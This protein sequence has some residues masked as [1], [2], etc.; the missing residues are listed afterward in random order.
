MTDRAILF[1]TAFL[2]ALATGL[3]GVLLGIY[4]DKLAFPPAQIGL[5]IGAG[6]TGAA[7]STFLVT[8][9][10]DRLG[11][12]RS[13]LALSLASAA[14]GFALLFTTSW[15][16]VCAVAFFGM[17]NGMG[18]D[19]G[20]ALVLEQAILPGTV[21]DAGRT[22]VFAW[23]NVLQD[24][25]HAI[26]G[27]LAVLPGAARLLTGAEEIASFQLA[28]ALYAF[29]LLASGL[30][31]LRLTPAIGAGRWASARPAS[32]RIGA[33]EGTTAIKVSPHSRKMLGKISALFALDSLAGGFLGTALMAYFFYERFGASEAAIALLFFL[34]RIANAASHLGAARLARR[35][36]LV[37]TMVFTHIPSSLI[38]L[39]V[40]FAPDFW[41]A[42]LLFL[43]RESLVEMDVPTRQSY[44][45][46]MVRP[47]ERTAASG[48]THLVRTGGWAAAPY[49]AGFLMQGVTL[50]MPI[51]IGAG[52]KILYDVLLFRA[53]R[54]LK[55]PEEQAR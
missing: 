32:E 31:Y 6:L 9:L 26:G 53:F 43:L 37:N 25:G 48:V 34:A 7:A 55:P 49:F 18:R 3:I 52:M 4:L 30:L 28:V 21:T 14:G 20:A 13:L 35:I 19:R 5:V 40:P 54:H 46:A 11:R 51:F 17:M 29:L 47:E 2:R 23:Y 16:A 24:I 41:I 50:A 44:V 12:R 1:A 15:L 39:T 27:L 8:L 36:G 33:R 10:G 45:M 38:L 42:A 22:R